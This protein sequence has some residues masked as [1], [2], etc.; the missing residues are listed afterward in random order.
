MATRPGAHVKTPDII[1]EGATLLVVDDDLR[2]R[3][4][5]K[6]Y[7]QPRFTV[8]EAEDGAGALQ[9]L[10]HH[11]VDLVLLDILMP[12]M[13]GYET[14]ERIKHT[15]RVGYLPVLLLTALSA[16]EHRNRGLSVGADDFLTKPVNRQ[17]LLLRVQAFLRLRRQEALIRGHLADITRM[18]ALKDDLFSLIV[19][20]LRNPL[21]SI[22]GYLQLLQESTEE[23]AHAALHADVLSAREATHRLGCILDDV[24]FVRALE[25]GELPLRLEPVCVGQ[26]VQDAVGMLDGMARSRHVHVRCSVQVQVK[27][28]ADAALLKRCVENLLVNAI[29]FSPSQMDV[30]VSVTQ[31][32]GDVVVEVG[33]QGPGIPDALKTDLFEKHGSLSSRQS[34][35]PR[36]FGL[37]LH[38]VKMVA[39]AHGGQ[40]RVQD[41]A[42]GGS[43]FIFQLP[44]STVSAAPGQDATR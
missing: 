29:K 16:Q 34:N 41:R 10:E 26:L 40:V 6:A 18:Q 42:G 3:E 27:T 25:Q 20:D 21:T 12:N 22:D 13:D 33:D 14:C 23:P 44:A 24:L 11:Q 17:E 8:L 9:S 39:Q 4:L 19:H 7:L 35:A 31:Q 38:L 28:Q 37:G 43:L 30:E 36:G 32:G 1:T 2:N 5:L 15:V